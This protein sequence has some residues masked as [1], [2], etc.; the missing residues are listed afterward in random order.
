MSLE[1]VLSCVQELLEKKPAGSVVTAD[2]C[3]AALKSPAFAGKV[4][5]A[6]LAAMKAEIEAYLARKQK[7]PAAAQSS[8]SVAAA[9]SDEDSDDDA[10]FEEEEES[11]ESEEEEEGEEEESEED[12]EPE[13]KMSRVELGSSSDENAKR[14]SDMVNCLRKLR[15][16][17]RAIGK[18]ADGTAFEESPEQY[19]STY[20]VPLFEKNG[21]DPNRFSS[22]DVTRYKLLKE[23]EALERDGANISLDRSQRQGRAT[24]A[25]AAPPPAP[26][27]PAFMDD[28]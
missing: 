2:V 8:S 15:V 1:A 16:R 7:A 5:G 23:A 27:K 26:P 21:F 9:G 13:T 20:L 22:S 28:E 14:A 25:N 6:D 3:L 11:E 18:Q 12:E 19:I 17:I 4:A 10:S 24:F